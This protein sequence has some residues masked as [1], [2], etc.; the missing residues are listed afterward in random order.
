MT[1]RKVRAKDFFGKFDESGDG[2][3]DSEELMKG[4]SRSHGDREISWAVGAKCRSQLKAS[5]KPFK[6]DSKLWKSIEILSKT[7][8]NP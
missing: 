6:T 3:I 4:R 1:T 2:Q 5:S 8:K 7:M